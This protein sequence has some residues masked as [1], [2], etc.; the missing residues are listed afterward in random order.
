MQP[1][2]DPTVDMEAGSG[3]EGGVGGGE[4]DGGLGHFPGLGDAL[5]GV[6]LGEFVELLG[7][8]LKAGQEHGGGGGGG[9]DGVHA[10][11]GAEVDG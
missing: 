7:L 3:D 6:H 2:A 11:A 8:S 1:P 5:D 4:E 9:V 10:D